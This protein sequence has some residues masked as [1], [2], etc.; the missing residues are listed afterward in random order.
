MTLLS[1]EE[2]I[3]FLDQSFTR[4]YNVGF[5]KPELKYLGYIID[6][7]GLRV[8]PEKVQSILNISTPT[9]KFVVSWE[10]RNGTDDLYPIFPP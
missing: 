2:H 4:L 9:K 6:K 5:C 10:W 8:D 3:N 1:F 7:K